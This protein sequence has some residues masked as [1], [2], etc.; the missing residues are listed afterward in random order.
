MKTQSIEALLLLSNVFKRSQLLQLAK[1]LQQVEL[2]HLDTIFQQMEAEQVASRD[3]L[4]NAIQDTLERQRQTAQ[5]VKQFLLQF[6]KAKLKP[7]DAV[8]WL[9]VELDGLGVGGQPFSGATSK[10]T[11]QKWL[12]QL[13]NSD[14]AIQARSA[15]ESVANKAA[16]EAERRQESDTTA[17]EIEYLFFSRHKRKPEDAVQDLSHQLERDGIYEEFKGRATKTTARNWF[18]DLCAKHSKEKVMS[19][20]LTAVQN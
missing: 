20:A 11:L 1:D 6:D 12:T 15:A 13:L 3:A 17:K 18:A 2:S 8:E 9:Q 5:D 16:L 19:A 10:A 14:L 7:A 4:A